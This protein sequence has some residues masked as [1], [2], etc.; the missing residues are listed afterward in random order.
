MSK[1]SEPSG[2]PLSRRELEVLELVA[3][4]LSN[5]QIGARMWITEGTV[6]RHIK[7]IFTKLGAVSRAD[8]VQKAVEAAII[9]AVP[10]RPAAPRPPRLG[11]RP[12]LT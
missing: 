4:A 9:P 5:A 8:A 1:S 6:K 11:W 7:S 3:R 2:I 12:G 10:A